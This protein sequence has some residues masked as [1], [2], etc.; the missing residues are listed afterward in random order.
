M[1]WIIKVNPLDKYKQKNKRLI[2]FLKKYKMVLR[3]L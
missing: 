3:Y 1:K 2:S